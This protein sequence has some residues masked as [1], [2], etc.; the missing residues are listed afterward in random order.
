[1]SKTLDID[2]D[3]RES[4]D[5]QVHGRPL[6]AAFPSFSCPCSASSRPTEGSYLY[7]NGKP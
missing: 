2:E 1:M 3:A 6:R 4:C 7:A 5:E